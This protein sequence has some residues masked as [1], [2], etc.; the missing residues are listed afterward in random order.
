[1]TSGRHKYSES[2]LALVNFEVSIMPSWVVEEWNALESNHFY[3][4]CQVD[5]D[6]SISFQNKPCLDPH[7]ILSNRSM[8]IILTKALDLSF[9]ILLLMM[10]IYG[11][12]GRV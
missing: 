8:C 9:F 6:F 3:S 5:W 4:S 2:Y 10:A 7:L 12:Q 1:M 11:A